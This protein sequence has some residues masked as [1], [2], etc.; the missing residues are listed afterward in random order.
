MKVLKRIAVT[1][2]VCAYI[3]GSGSEISD[4]ATTQKQTSDVMADLQSCRAEPEPAKRL[5]CYD[6]L[7]RRNSPPRFSGKLGMRTEPFEINRP[8]LLRFRSD[9]VI[10][11]LYVLD[12]K[13]DVVQ[14]LHIGGGGEDSYLIE[15]PGIY[16]LQIDGSAE[17]RIWLDPVSE[18]EREGTIRE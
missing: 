17:W 11:V 12:A 5:A 14:N 8:Y 4:A 3:N 13:G 10:F 16:S 2:L 18:H 6:N 1:L 15:K 7:A 9:G